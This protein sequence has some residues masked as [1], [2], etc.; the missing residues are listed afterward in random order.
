MA[1]GIFERMQQILRKRAA[2]GDGPTVVA[3]AGA[4]AAGAGLG[5]DRQ[6][7]VAG[8]EA[9]AEAGA[10][11]AGAGLGTDRQAVVAGAEAGAEAGAGTAGAGPGT[12]RQAVVAGAEAGAEAGAGTAGAGPGTDRQAV[13]AEAGA[14]AG[15]GTA[16]AGPGTDRQAV[17]AGAEAGAEA[18]A[19]PGTDRQAVVAGLRPILTGTTGAAKRRRTADNDDKSAP[20][21]KKP[22]PLRSKIS[23]SNGKRVITLGE[24][25]LWGA[26]AREDRADE[27]AAKQALASVFPDLSPFELAEIARFATNMSTSSAPPPTDDAIDAR[28][29]ALRRAEPAVRKRENHKWRTV[30]G[31]FQSR[32]PRTARNPD[33]FLPPSAWKAFI[34]IA[35]QYEAQFFDFFTSK[36][37]CRGSFF[38]PGAPCPANAAVDFLYATPAQRASFTLDHTVEVHLILKHWRHRVE[39]EAWL[40]LPPRHRDW[41]MRFY[42]FLLLGLRPQS[43]AGVTYEP[44]LVGRCSFCDST[45]AHGLLLPPFPP[46][47]SL[48]PQDPSL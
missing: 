19:G 23:T 28:L 7:V 45:K 48:H 6:A 42:A 27:R 26:L 5:T 10:G 11:A 12:D 33:G 21:R 22:V 24:G 9:G 18:G 43:F 47:P 1:D 32:I 14:E 13:V 31:R 46:L 41:D 30:R 34:G 39:A 15:A 29:R 40:D 3:G 38:A 35:A 17:V 37:T 20:R 25:G 44:N 2:A 8:A 4:G 36:F 16:G